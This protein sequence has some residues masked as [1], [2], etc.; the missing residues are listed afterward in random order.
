MAVGFD[1]QDQLN[2]PDALDGF[3]ERSGR[4][5][6]DLRQDAAHLIKLRAAGGIFFLC[7]HVCSKMT[8][9][10]G[11]VSDRFQYD[12]NS[13]IENSFVDG[14]RIGQIERRSA[15]FYLGFVALQTFSQDAVVVD[16]QVRRCRSP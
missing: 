12:Q 14:I 8:V 2:Q 5:I 15:T 10:K 4:F 6:G 3:A 1:L 13:L 7:S 16:G 11:K 9:A